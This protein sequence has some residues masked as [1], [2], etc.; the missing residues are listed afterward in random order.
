MSKVEIDDISLIGLSLKAK[1]T[2]TNGQILKSHK[3]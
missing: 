1:T 3:D 2:N